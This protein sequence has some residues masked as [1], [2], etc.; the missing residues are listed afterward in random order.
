MAVVSVAFPLDV[1]ARWGFGFPYR[2]H[3]DSRPPSPSCSVVDTQPT[4]P[5]LRSSLST[6][7]GAAALA[8]GSF[9]PLGPKASSFVLPLSTTPQD[10]SAS[11]V[12]LLPTL[13]Q[14]PGLLPTHSRVLAAHLS[15]SWPLGLRRSRHSMHRTST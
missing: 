13:C 10:Q 12:Q 6:D 3:C 9:C 1:L 14:Y 11:S 5:A 8:S 15:P 2:M 4:S 7:P